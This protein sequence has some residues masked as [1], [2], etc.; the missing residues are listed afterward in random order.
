MGKARSLPLELRR[1]RG[2]IL[3]G[4]SIAWK[5]YSREEVT[6]NGKHSS[7]LSYSNNNGYKS[8]IQVP[9]VKGQLYRPFMAVMYCYKLERGPMPFTST[10]V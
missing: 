8:V 3:V 7:L 1:V 6:D 5:Y 4:S 2:C 9:S 10:L